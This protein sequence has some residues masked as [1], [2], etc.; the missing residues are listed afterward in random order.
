MKNTPFFVLSFVIILFLT[1]CQKQQSEPSSSGVKSPLEMMVAD[2]VAKTF[3]N[4]L[5]STRGEKDTLYLHAIFCHYPSEDSSIRIFDST[6]TLDVVAAV[7]GTENYMV[8]PEL[9]PPLP[10]LPDEMDDGYDGYCIDSLNQLDP[11]L[12]GYTYFGPIQ[13]IILAREDVDRSLVDP[14]LEGVDVMDLRPRYIEYKKNTKGHI[15]EG[16]GRFNLYSIDSLGIFKH[17]GGFVI[18]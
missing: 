11:S 10:P 13:V 8:Y 2:Y 14:F 15:M 17:V 3:P 18:D 7:G 9:V 5:D 4:W 12:I 1:S 16:W 6:A